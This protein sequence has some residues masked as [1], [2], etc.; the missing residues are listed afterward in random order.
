[1]K[2]EKLQKSAWIKF[3]PDYC[4]GCQTCVLACAACHGGEVNPELSRIKWREDEFEGGGKGLPAFCI[5]C[6]NPKCFWACEVHAFYID[7]ETGAR[8]IDPEK[9][10][11]CMKCIDACPFGPSRIGFDTEK[12]IAIKCDLCSGNPKCVEVC[13]NQALTLV[14][15]KKE[16]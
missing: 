14:K 11:G 15:P 16:G 7:K 4:I 9:C 6:A 5:Q 12:K 1:M 10:I 2:P 13:P 8:I 3:S